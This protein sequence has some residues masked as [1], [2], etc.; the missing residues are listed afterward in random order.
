M[1]LG[2]LPTLVAIPLLLVACGDDDESNDNTFFP[3]TG[4]DD[5]GLR[6]FDDAVLEGPNGIER[7]LS[8]DY[9]I[10]NIDSIDCPADQEVKVGSKFTCTV[11]QGGDDPKELTVEITV[12]GDDGTYQVALPEEKK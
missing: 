8:M 1:R 12:V 3:P 11:T 5:G 10:E 2:V 6:V 7:I 9:K 4:A